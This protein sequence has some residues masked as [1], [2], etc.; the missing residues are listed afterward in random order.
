MEISFSSVEQFENGH[1]LKT[2][3]NDEMTRAFLEDTVRSAMDYG[4]PVEAVAVAAPM[5]VEEV[6]GI[7]NG[8]AAA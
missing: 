6:A 4:Y 7:A 3:D 5:S 8:P 1:R 2:S